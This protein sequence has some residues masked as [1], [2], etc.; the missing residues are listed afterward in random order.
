MKDQ[1]NPAPK[2]FKCLTCNNKFSQKGKQTWLMLKIVYLIMCIL[3]LAILFA[4]VDVKII[5]NT[6]K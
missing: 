2:V 4:N 5:S 6:F 1:A 3:I